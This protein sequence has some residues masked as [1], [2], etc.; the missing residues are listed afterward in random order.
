[1]Y[2]FVYVDYSREFIIWNDAT[3]FC[4]I[5]SLELHIFSCLK[6]IKKKIVHT[7]TNAGSNEDL[8]NKFILR[9]KL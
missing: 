1:M 8:I 4:V 5:H 6:E 2:V 9:F 3:S 7:H